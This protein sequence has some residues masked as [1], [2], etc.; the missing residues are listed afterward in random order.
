MSIPRPTR[1]AARRDSQRLRPALFTALILSSAGLA[2]GQDEATARHVLN[3]MAH[4][5]TPEAL[6]EISGGGVTTWI[7]QQ[8]AITQGHPNPTL[9]NL[10]ATIVDLPTYNRQREKY[11]LTDVSLLQFA[12][13]LYSRDQ[14]T[15]RMTNFWENHFNVGHNNIWRYWRNRFPEVD[16]TARG[17]ATYFTWL[18]NSDFRTNGLGRFEDLLTRSAFSPGM[19]V[20]LDG[21]RSTKSSPNENY[22]RELLELYTLGVGQFAQADVLEGS[23]IFTGIEVERVPPGQYGDPLADR[24]TEDVAWEMGDLNF[25]SNVDQADQDIV[26]NNWGTSGPEGDVN[27][28]GNVNF[29]DL[30]IVLSNLGTNSW[31]YGPWFNEADYSP[32]PK[33]FFLGSPTISFTITPGPSPTR[34]EKFAESTTYL[35]HLASLPRT[36]EY[37][38]SK[39]IASFVYPIDPDGDPGLWPADLEP[40]RAQCAT[41]WLQT[42]GNM[43][44]VLRTIFESPAFLSNLDHRGT[45]TETAFESVVSTVR[46]MESDFLLSPLITTR[47]QLETMRSAVEVSARQRLFDYPAPDGY[48]PSPP[49]SANLLARMNFNATAFD[50]GFI[51]PNWFDLLPGSYPNDKAL[52]ISALGHAYGSTAFSFPDAVQAW[53]YLAYLRTQGTTAFSD[54]LQA[55]A[56]LITSYPQSFRK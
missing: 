28:D 13:A 10:V 36:A 5:P 27:K 34:A 14:L 15:E 26:T 21:T 38:S 46:I 18:E 48:H 35:N 42:G 39:L 50:T 41:T 22:S 49:G 43:R 20:Y 8:L 47:P 55:L 56:P 23:K 44:E 54:L 30:G 37:V 24:V 16:N 17:I 31:V 9:A 45:L 32:G 19:L 7:N 33:E 1:R 52:A 11:L 4:G 12:Q 51:D 53:T 2:Q 6:E 25:D 3:R 29:V 40:L